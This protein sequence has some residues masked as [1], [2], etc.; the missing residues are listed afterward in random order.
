[1]GEYDAP[2]PPDAAERDAARR[3]GLGEQDDTLHGEDIRFTTKRVSAEERA[4]VIAVLTRVRE[5]ETRQAKR[6]ERRDREPW[7]R[8]QRVPEGIGDLL[9]EA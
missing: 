5:E 7:A 8:S 4:A 9:A 2:L 3:E 6:V 1:M